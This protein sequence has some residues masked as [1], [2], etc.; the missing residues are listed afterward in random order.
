MAN[1]SQVFNL[2][3]VPED[4][5]A[6]LPAGEYTAQ[7]V[8]SEMKETRSGNGMYLELRVQ[9]LDD[10]YTGRLVFDRLNLVNPNE[11]AVK[12]AQRSLSDL[13]KAIGLDESPEDS[14]ELHGKEFTVVLSVE[15][16]NGDFPESN[17]VK[18]YK[19]A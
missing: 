5:Y 13:C 17:R 3:E 15:E 19:A 12:I 18:K 4:D 2:N 8:R 10:P 11:V 14:E 16:A 6:V 7:I 9:I 1:L